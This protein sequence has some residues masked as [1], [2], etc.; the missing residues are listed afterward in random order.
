M[1]AYICNLTNIKFKILSITEKESN[2]G[3]FLTKSRLQGNIYRMISSKNVHN[4]F[5]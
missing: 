4:V 3:A 2:Y 5:A 1:H